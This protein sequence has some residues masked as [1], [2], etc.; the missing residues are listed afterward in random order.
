MNA[1]W[2]RASRLN[3]LDTIS[4][5]LKVE[6]EA[7]KRRKE[8]ELAT[9]AQL[10]G[11][12]SAT[13]KFRSDSGLTADICS[14]IL[15]E[16]NADISKVDTVHDADKTA[17]H[18]ETKLGVLFSSSGKTKWEKGGS[19]C[20]PVDVMVV[21]ANDPCALMG[22][23]KFGLK[24]DNAWLFR[25][26]GQFEKEFHRK[27]S[28][29]GKFLIEYDNVS[30]YEFMMLIVTS[31]MAP[32]LINRFNDFMLEMG[33]ADIPYDKIIVCSVDDIAAKAKETMSW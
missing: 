9:F 12:E 24:S 19:G 13:A 23:C 32:L 2:V 25:D 29:V 14:R 6:L 18:G 22:D 4:S 5:V 10:K 28:S 1:F 33:N 3:V 31:A 16:V 27:F 30:S 11:N 26:K 21:R 15:S 20:C 8:G 7:E 17:I